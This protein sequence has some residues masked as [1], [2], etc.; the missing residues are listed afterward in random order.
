LSISNPNS[1]FRNPKWSHM[2]LGYRIIRPQD[3]GSQPLLF[4]QIS[5]WRTAAWDVAE[6]E[7]AVTEAIGIASAC[8]ARGIRTVFHP[9]EYPLTNAYAAQTLDVMRRLAAASDLGIIL[10]DEGGAD[11]KGLSAAEAAEFERNLA[12]ISSLCPVSIENA[13][14]SGDITRFWDRFVVTAPKS[15]SITLDIGHLESADI[16]AIAFVR[17]LPERLASRVNFAH[18]H[19]KAEERYG[20]K[21]HWP[22][23]A[24]CREIEAL[25]ELLKRRPGVKVVLEL[26]AAEDGMSRSIELLKTI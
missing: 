15:V 23:V 24:D 4:A 18:M 7:R 12:A 2:E 8:T 16:D 14:N 5:L 6:G 26:D 10:H 21:D 3:V 20:I 11:G 17:D 19:H 1:A 9:L 25:R 13:F 22:L